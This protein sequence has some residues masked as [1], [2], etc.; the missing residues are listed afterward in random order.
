MFGWRGKILRVDLSNRVIKYEKLDPLIAKKYIGGRGLGIY[1]MLN[2]LDPNCDPLSK[3]NLLIMANGPLTGTGAPTGSRYMVM[4]KS[5]LTGAITCSNSGGIFPT[6]F[7]R[8]GLDA[9]II[10]GQA[11]APVYLWI[12]QGIAEL[13][14]ADHLWGK[15][16]HETTDALL[17]EIDPKARIA[18]IG[19]AGERAV[20]FASIMNDKNRAAGRSGVGAVMGSKNLKAVAVR[21]KGSIP[22]ADSERFKEFNRQV[23]DLFKKGV[24]KTQLG[25]T[26]NGTAGVVVATQNFGILPTKNWQQGTFDGWEKIQGEELTKQFLLKNTACYGCPIGC[27]RKTKIDDPCFYG[28]GEGP[29]YETIYAMGSNCMVDDL[30]AITKANYI[31]NE[32]G[33]D[34]IT[35]GATI[36]CAM[37][38]FD[39]KY[40]PEDHVGRTLE[41]GDG[42]AVV[43]LTRMTGYRKGFGA[44]VWLIDTA[45][46]NW[47]SY[48]RNKSFPG[49]IRVVPKE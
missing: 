12:D 15:D 29:E 30:A 4:S 40:L 31:C 25:L 28:E 49:M 34:T 8:T 7:K 32:L 5:P 47:Q 38:L 20:L 2:E 46:Q 41:W 21:G 43:E 13:R 37:E 48:L 16:T 24:K 19:P 26:V 22:I 27:G 36:G 9:I 39:S 17:E 35:M 18:C 14:K 45:I 42:E 6:V 1:Y 3:E 10:S 11:D 33:M 44:I 23:M